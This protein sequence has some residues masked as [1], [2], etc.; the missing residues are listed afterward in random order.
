[1]FTARATSD[2]VANH[3]MRHPYVFTS[4]LGLLLLWAWSARG[5]DWP[6]FRGPT[7]DGVSTEPISVNWSA[8]GL[9]AVWTNRTLTNGFSSVAVS[10]GR[11]FVMMSRDDG[12]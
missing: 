2:T 7:T 6:Q 11:A 4:A 10:Q 1:D 3:P 8:G 5:T 12:G 9:T